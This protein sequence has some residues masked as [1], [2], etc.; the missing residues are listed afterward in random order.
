MVSTNYLSNLVGDF[1]SIPDGNEKIAMP[2]FAEVM[3]RHHA[4]QSAQAQVGMLPYDV[5]N[6]LESDTR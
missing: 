4:A 6:L 2:S 3:G 5:C 1:C